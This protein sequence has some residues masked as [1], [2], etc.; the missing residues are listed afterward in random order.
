M[1]A[2]AP[3]HGF[4]IITIDVGNMKKPENYVLVKELGY[5]IILL[6]IRSLRSHVL[7]SS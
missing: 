3:T 1:S 2:I 4:K 6:N 7:K 5:S